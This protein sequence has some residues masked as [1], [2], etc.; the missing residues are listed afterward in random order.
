LREPAQ[1]EIAHATESL[2]RHFLDLVFRY[3]NF[4][5]GKASHDFGPGER[6]G[7]VGSRSPLVLQE[8]RAIAEAKQHRV[9]HLF[10]RIGLI[11]GR[12]FY[13]KDQQIAAS[14]RLRACPRSA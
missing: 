1:N 7:S 6:H 3:A 13:R 9:R 11:G 8:E 12:A 14:C 4:R 10:D 2:L 5:V